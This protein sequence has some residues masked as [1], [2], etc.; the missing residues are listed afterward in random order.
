MKHLVLQ[1][2]FK[3]INNL[4][5][6]YNRCDWSSNIKDPTSILTPLVQPL[7]HRSDRCTPPVRPV[8][9]GALRIHRSDR[10]IDRLDR[11]QQNWQGAH[12]TQRWATRQTSNLGV[13]LLDLPPLYIPA[14]ELDTT[15]AEVDVR[16]SCNKKKIGGNKPWV[17]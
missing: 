7:H 1:A 8:C 5:N 2:E 11:S 3:Y 12:P 17:F 9:M 15:G 13:S 4:Q 16:V 6:F 14:D 10:S